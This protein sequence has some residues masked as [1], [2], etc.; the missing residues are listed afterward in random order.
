MS[1][2]PLILVIDDEKDFLEIFKIKFSDAGFRVES[3]ESGSAGI[4]KAKELKPDLILMDVKM[5]I[6]DGVEALLKLKEAPET[7]NIKV[8]FLT[9]LGGIEEEVQ[10]L[11][12]RYA[13]EIGA[14][15]YIRKTDD[16]GEMTERVKSFLDQE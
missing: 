11:N 6:M 4:Q 2:V 15:G 9:S 16:L 5:P 7:K 1:Q 13:K 12:K 10:G 3:A 8:V 14:A